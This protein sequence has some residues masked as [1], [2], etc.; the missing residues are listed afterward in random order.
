MFYI[1]PAWKN[2]KPEITRIITHN[3][4]FEEH[5]ITGNTA[6]TTIN[7]DTKCYMPSILFLWSEKNT[8]DILFTSL[9]RGPNSK[10]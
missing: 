4:C 3:L 9:L 5:N 6:M 1:I 10:E 2:P 8:S 7:S